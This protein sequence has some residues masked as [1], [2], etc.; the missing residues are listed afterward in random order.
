MGS[1]YIEKW[2]NTNDIEVQDLYRY[3]GFIIGSIIFVLNA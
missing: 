1:I 3:V 2:N